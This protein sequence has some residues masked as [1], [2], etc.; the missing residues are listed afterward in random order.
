[1]LVAATDRNIP[2][3]F[4]DFLMAISILHAF[5]TMWKVLKRCFCTEMYRI[6]CQ[7]WRM[8]LVDKIPP[9]KI[10][11]LVRLAK[12]CVFQHTTHLMLFTTGLYNSSLRCLDCRNLQHSTESFHDIIMQYLL[13]IQ[14]SKASCRTTPDD[15]YCSVVCV[16]LY[17]PGLVCTGRCRYVAEWPI[18]HIMI[19]VRND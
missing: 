15:T 11:L 6:S 17:M 4:V 2:E 3:R 1:M 12:V 9:V 5:W 18:W 8:V 19:V 10:V 7:Y 13:F 14:R 16:V